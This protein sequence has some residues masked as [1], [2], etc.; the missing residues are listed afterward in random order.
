VVA[1][2]DGQI[3][4]RV[5]QELDLPERPV[6]ADLGC[7][8]GQRDARVMADLGGTVYACE[9]DPAKAELASSF[10]KVDVCDVRDW[11]PPEPLDPI[12]WAELLEHLPAVDQ[13]AFLRKLR[14]ALAEGGRLILSTPQRHSPVASP[15][16]PRPGC[17]DGPPTTG[18]TP[19]TSACSA[20]ATSRPWWPHRGSPST[21]DSAST[22]S[23]T[24]SPSGRCNQTVHE[25][26]P[27]MLGFDLI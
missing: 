5:I 19:P 14:A 3:L 27:G 15:R 23:P 16:G 22:S 7:G 11:L 24:S 8:D 9:L 12:L 26:R 6:A 10:A 4:T 13:P 20:A 21:G 2:N 17:G 1:R 25:G 18:G